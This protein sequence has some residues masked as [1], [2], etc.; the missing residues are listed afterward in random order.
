MRTNF[1]EAL[2]Y[3]EQQLFAPSDGCRLWPYSKLPTGYGQVWCPAKRKPDS[4]ARLTCEA[5][6]GPKPFP[7]AVVAHSCGNPECWAGEHLRWTTCKENSADMIKHGRSTR[8][9][10]NPMSK[11]TRNEVQEIRALYKSGWL[12]RQIAE[13]FDIGRKTVSNI[14]IG[15]S[16]YW[17][18]PHSA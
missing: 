9:E 10:I 11:L 17:L 5:W 3:F 1:R 4:V 7:D 8:G 15:N 12:Q 2:T 6:Y 14:I 13:K 18:K 16:W